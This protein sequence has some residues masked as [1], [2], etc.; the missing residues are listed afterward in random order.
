MRHHDSTLNGYAHFFEAMEGHGKINFEPALLMAYMHQWQATGNTPR[1]L[2]NNLSTLRRQARR[3]RLEFPDPKSADWLDI[4][5]QLR[6]QKKLD[7]TETAHATVMTLHKIESVLDTMGINSI[8]DLYTCTPQTLQFV[9]RL[10]VCHATMARGCEHRDGFKVSDISA[11]HM[12]G[13]NGVIF[14][15]VAGRDDYD[16]DD[17]LRRMKNKL[18]PARRC[19]LAV[20]PLRVSAGAC[21]LIYME[22]MAHTFNGPD[23]ILFPAIEHG[24]KVFKGR[25]MTDKQ[26]YKLLRVY[27]QR[28]GMAA[29]QIANLTAHSLRAG[30]ATD[31]L[32]GGMSVAW[33]K[34]QGG[35]ES[36]AYLTYYRPQ[37]EH[38]FATARSIIAVTTDLLRSCRS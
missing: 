3:L 11:G 13:D 15:H 1:S 19:E 18:R 14:L 37:P 24:N 29:V 5:D 31:F 2:D 26:F 12:E 32:I 10:L 35:W 28:A 25:A 6:G 27:A 4:R 16:A 17:P 34:Q 7:P 8:H 20:F 33:V 9:T 36:P 23:D 38:A 30:G 22:R 21:L